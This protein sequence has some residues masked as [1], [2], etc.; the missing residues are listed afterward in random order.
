MQPIFITGTGTGIGKTVVSAIVT[1]AL[2]ADYWK[3]IQ[4]GL[5]EDTDTVTVKKLISNSTSSFHNEGYR[6]TTPA[7]PH[8]AA[9]NEN[10]TI[11]LDKLERSFRHLSSINDHLIIEGPGGILV[12]LNDDEFV[13]DLIAKLD[14][15][16]ILVSR[17]YLGS[18][19]HSLLTAQYCKQK[20]LNVCGWIFNDEF[21]DYENDIVKWS[22]YEKIASIPRAGNISK[23]FIK[24]QAQLLLPAL[25]RCL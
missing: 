24:E 12:P 19:N 20:K 2:K 4:A 23:E 14:T 25:K 15:K 8:I 11:N 16:V 5:E 9:K 10:V 1:E 22:G 6:L 17:N 3:P 21:M 13:G 7:S 18:I